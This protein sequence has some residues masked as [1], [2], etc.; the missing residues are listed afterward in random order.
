MDENGFGA[1]PPASEAIMPLPTA[2]GSERHIID[3]MLLETEIALENSGPVT[4]ENALLLLD[5]ASLLI[6][7]S[8]L[9]GDEL[10]LPED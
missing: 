1:S 9:L 3:L 2:N 6:D 5:I 4:P 10:S 8:T 7:S